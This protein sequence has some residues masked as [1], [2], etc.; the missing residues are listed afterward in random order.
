MN[1]ALEADAIQ[2]LYTLLSDDEK[3]RAERL[4]SEYHR[5]HFVAARGQLRLVLTRYLNIRNDEISFQYNQYGKPFLNGY[6]IY[7]NLS[8]SHNLALIALNESSDLGVDIEW[9]LRKTKY[10]QI[11]K[12]FFSKNEY[13]QLE[14]LPRAKQREGFFNC[15]TRKESYIKARGKGLGIPLDGFEVSLIP[16]GPVDLKST[17]HDPGAVNQWRLHAFDPYREYKG[18]VTV[19]S[20]SDEIKLIDGLNL[21]GENN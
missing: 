1:T 6:P 18:A 13:S 3:T 20:N 9:I 4:Y 10:L 7:F 11:G 16:G 17:R 8:H 2:Q 15:W 14:S 21:S 19:N 5:S 12:R